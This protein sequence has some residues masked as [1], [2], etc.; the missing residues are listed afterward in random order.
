MLDVSFSHPLILL[1]L[2]LMPV[3]LLFYF[4]N[5]RKQ[6]SVIQLSSFGGFD[7]Y[8]KTFR[9]RLIHLPFLLR[10]FGISFL[11]IAIADPKST[12]LTQ[13]S[14]ADS[15]E[16]VYVIDQSSAMLARDFRPNRMESLRTGLDNF[17]DRHAIYPSGLVSF[18]EGASTL[19]PVTDDRQALKEKL[20]SLPAEGHIFSSNL[21]QGIM[22]GLDLLNQN[23]AKHKFLICFTA[24]NNAGQPDYLSTSQSIDSAHAKL[25]LV[26]VAS[27]GLVQTLVESSG[28]LMYQ[29][30]V[31][32]LDETA[33][34]QLCK[35]KGSQYIRA[36]SETD[37]DGSFITMGQLLDQNK[38]S[39]TKNY[40][41][42]FPF[43]WVAA[44]FLVLEIMLRYTYLKSLP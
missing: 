28:K 27:E 4:R 30:S 6:R 44:G 5:Y 23:A 42:I 18:G 2:E 38:T 43:A 15:T 37:L 22:T 33:F 16:V 34:H 35:A 25:F 12:H 17:I 8:R 29:N 40:Q 21:N 14:Q 39:W 7:E 20:D 19:S 32:N 1:L 26:A 11:I 36:A 9:Q 3:L 24:S 41:G 31:I 10:I 13:V